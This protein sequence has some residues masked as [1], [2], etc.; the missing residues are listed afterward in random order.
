MLSRVG[1]TFSE[2]LCITTH[3]L[4]LPVKLQLDVLHTEIAQFGVFFFH[5]PSH[6][7]YLFLFSTS[8]LPP[9]QLVYGFTLGHIYVCV[10]I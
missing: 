7:A 10:C 1:L 5:F 4:L 9:K 8:V 2:I 3:I 6:S